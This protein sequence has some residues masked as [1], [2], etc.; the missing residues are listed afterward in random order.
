MIPFSIQLDLT[1]K[2]EIES[3]Q[4]GNLDFEK[5]YSCNAVDI[6]S[7][8]ESEKLSNILGDHI[9]GK[10]KFD[11][12]MLSILEQYLSELPIGLNEFFPN[13]KF[14]KVYNSSLEKMTKIGFKS[15]ENLKEIDIEENDLQD[16][17][18]DTFDD[19]IHLEFL[20]LAHNKMQKL[21]NGIFKNL[22]ELKTLLLKGNYLRVFGSEL[23]QENVN[24]EFLD[25]SNN[26]LQKIDPKTFAHLKN[27]KSL[28]LSGSWCI[29][30]YD[31]F[32]SVRNQDMISYLEDHSCATSCEEIT[33]E[34]ANL[35]R[36]NGER[37]VEV[38]QITLET[39]KLKNRQKACVVL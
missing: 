1:C 3:N 19:L 9:E 26:G 12:A 4:G 28:Y 29:P 22:I 20:N 5:K 24:L 16:L 23:I 10:S 37:A 6:D 18:G 8:H 27:L 39:E 33:V 17:P 38:E 13:L 35:I 34:L 36:D 30:E 11:V 21:S 15:L 7:L 31:G 25:L 32:F 2:F 14:F